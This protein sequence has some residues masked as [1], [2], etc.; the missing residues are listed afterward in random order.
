MNFGQKSNLP[1]ST[2]VQIPHLSVQLCCVVS[3]KDSHPCTSKCLSKVKSNAMFNRQMHF[4]VYSIYYT[5][6]IEVNI[7]HLHLD[8]Y[9]LEFNCI[10]LRQALS[11]RNEFLSLR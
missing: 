8:I 10:L 7:L 3:L 11:Q 5:V 2:E 4:K 6:Y 1:N 9:K